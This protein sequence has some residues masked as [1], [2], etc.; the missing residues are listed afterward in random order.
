MS[1]IKIGDVRKSNR[2]GEYKI[3]QKVRLDKKYQYQYQY[4]IEFVLTGYTKWTSYASISKNEVRD[5]YYPIIY[6]ECCMGECN[7]SRDLYY[8]K[9]LNTWRGIVNRCYDVNNENYKNY[10]AK[11]IK[12]CDRW[13]CFENFYLDLPQVS[14][15]DKDKFL[16]REIVLDKDTKFSFVLHK[17][18]SLKNC[19][20]ISQKDNFQEGLARWKQRTSSRYVGITK[21]YDGKWQA[22]ICDMRKKEKNKNVYIGRYATEEEAHE[23][24]K[25]KRKE[26]YGFEEYE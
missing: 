5:P 17:Q 8:K 16:K 13:K 6:G 11:G 21:L 3:L 10:G 20:F 22:S 2:Y 15:F 1:K 25:K 24:Y 19:V 14:G 18:Y 26:L 4:Q 12:L 9:A 7:F 23:A